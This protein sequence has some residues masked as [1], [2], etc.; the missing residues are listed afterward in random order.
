MVAKFRKV[1]YILQPL[2]TYIIQCFCFKSET[3]NTDWKYRDAMRAVLSPCPQKDTS[4]ADVRRSMKRRLFA[5]PTIF[6][7]SAKKPK[8]DTEAANQTRS[9]ILRDLMRI[10]EN[11]EECERTYKKEFDSKLQ[12]LVKDWAN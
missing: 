12:M 11:F 2:Y 3:E 1:C 4:Q 7:G 9:G 5:S 8:V 6:F 10:Q